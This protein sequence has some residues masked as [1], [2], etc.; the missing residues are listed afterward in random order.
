MTPIALLFGV[1]AIALLLAGSL[2]WAAG[3]AG[4]LVAMRL[5]D[6][7]LP[8]RARIFWLYAF[9]LAFYTAVEWIVPAL[10]RAPVDGALLA[11]DRAL[12]G[13]TPAARFTPTPGWTD[14]LSGCYLS[15]HLYLH[16]ALIWAAVRIE[17]A[18][19]L[20]RPLFLAFAL[21]MAGYLMVPATGPAIA[22]PERFAIP[23]EGG[24]MTTVNQAFISRG[25]SLYD[26]FPSLH[27]LMTLTLLHHDWRWLRRRFW[28]ALGPAVGLTVSTLYLRYH[29]AVDLLAGVGVW[30][31]VVVSEARRGRA[32]QS[33]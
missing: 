33:R 21:G 28:I 3:L 20:V 16:G 18:G 25:T 29:Y 19:R 15:Y 27:V 30:L 5:V 6:R 12:F 24:W 31:V 9:T 17:T 8:P 14:L 32:A 22:F 26:V 23:I 1:T 13:E 10:G 11:A 4:A 2:V 7:R